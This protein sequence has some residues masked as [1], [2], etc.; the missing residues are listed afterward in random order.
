MLL[1][2][3]SY[4]SMMGIVI[5]MFLLAIPTFADPQTTTVHHECAQTTECGQ[6]DH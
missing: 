4:I 1:A 5:G 2:P 6:I 3:V